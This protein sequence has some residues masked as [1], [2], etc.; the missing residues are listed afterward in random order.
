[1]SDWERDIK[2]NE[3]TDSRYPDFVVTPEP[4]HLRTQF[5]QTRDPESILQFIVKSL[6]L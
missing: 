1:M 3:M 5:P 2:A 6:K 4:L